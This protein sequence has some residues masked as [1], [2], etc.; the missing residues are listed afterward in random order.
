MTIESIHRKSAP[1]QKRKLNVEALRDNEL[2]KKL[3]SSFELAFGEES[4]VEQYQTSKQHWS[5]SAEETI[6][7]AKKKNPDWFDENISII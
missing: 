2:T 6:G 3:Q 7:F 5:S 4:S 1:N